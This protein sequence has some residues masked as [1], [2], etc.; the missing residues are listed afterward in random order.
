MTL[1]MTELREMVAMTIMAYL[2]ES[3]GNCALEVDR[4]CDLIKW[5]DAR[6]FEEVLEVIRDEW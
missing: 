3:E 2:R 6:D 4:M 5:V 1:S